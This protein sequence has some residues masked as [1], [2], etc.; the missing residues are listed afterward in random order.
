MEPPLPS[1]RPSGASEKATSPVDLA[2][3]ITKEAYRLPPISKGH[4]QIRSHT[5]LGLAHHPLE[6]PPDPW[7]ISQP[8][9]MRR[10]G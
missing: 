5:G 10:Q 8:E 1:L 3:W 6:M 9:L 4:L 2:P 7:A